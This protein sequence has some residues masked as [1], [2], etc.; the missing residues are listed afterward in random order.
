MDK[1]IWYILGI[2]VLIIVGVLAISYHPGARVVPT[3]QSRSSITPSAPADIGSSSGESGQILPS[4]TPAKGAA[5]VPAQ[6]PA[7]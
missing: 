5:A 7:Q 3:E 6:P 2:A 1:D 4:Q